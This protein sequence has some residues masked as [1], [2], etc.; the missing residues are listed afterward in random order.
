M[1]AQPAVPAG[2]RGFTA[3]E[4][5]TVLVV[6][7]ILALVVVSRVGTT[8]TARL[9]S[10]TG[11]AVTKIRY[12][13]IR[14]IKSGTPWGIRCDGA[15]IWLFH[16]TDPTDPTLRERFPG[17]QDL[18]I[19]LASKDMTLTAFT[20]IFD[21]YGIPYVSYTDFVNNTKVDNTLNQVQVTVGIPG[22]SDTR[23]IGVTPE[24][25]LVS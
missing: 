3:V 17:E 10:R 22:Q 24:T 15:N 25:G 6:L 2:K 16:G 7:A 13:N 14:A 20:V 23:T 12:A 19:A 1:T 11:D 18:S 21:G 4:V 5:V 8:T 9:A